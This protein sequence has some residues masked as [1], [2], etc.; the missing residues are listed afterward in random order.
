MSAPITIGGGAEGG[1][2]QDVAEQVDVVSQALRS[3][4]VADVDGRW[5]TFTEI[6]GMEN[7][8]GRRISGCG[9]EEQCSIGKVTTTA[10]GR[11]T[12]TTLVT[13]ATLVQWSRRW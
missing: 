3:K 7:E 6:Y 10:A 11:S 8:A 12:V 2:G 1:G 13:P 4:N 9:R 5:C